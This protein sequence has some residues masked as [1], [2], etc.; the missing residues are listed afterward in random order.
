MNNLSIFNYGERKVRTVIRS[1]E[2]WFVAKDVCEILEIQN[3]NDAIGRLSDK[4]KGIANTNTLGGK[5][6]R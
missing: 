4:M 1:E 2:I 5:G 3:P 6:E